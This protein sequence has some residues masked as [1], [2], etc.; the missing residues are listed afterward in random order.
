V[1][2]PPSP[3]GLRLDAVWA[4]IARH[5]YEYLVRRWNWKAGVLS[6]MLRGAIFFATNLPA[7]RDAAV[8]ATLTEFCYRILLSGGIGSVTEALRK[9]EPAWAAAL[10]ASV[11]LPVFGHLMEFMV[12][13]LRGTPRIRTS[14]AVS[15]AFSIFSALFNLYVMRHGVLVVG[16]ERRALIEDLAALPWLLAKFL[17]AGPLALW[18]KLRRHSLP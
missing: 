6:G 14:I 10:T 15:I 13:F 3:C 9:C 2:S 17:A 7:G 5:P 1:T 4:D 16:G 8:G 18:R 12:H 11:A